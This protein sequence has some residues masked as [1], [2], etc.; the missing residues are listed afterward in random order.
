MTWAMIQHNAIL[1]YLASDANK[2]KR[3]GDLKPN[4]WF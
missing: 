3:G 2:N 1:F 4:M